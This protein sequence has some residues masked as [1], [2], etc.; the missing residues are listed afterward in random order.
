MN[1]VYAPRALRDLHGIS[2]YLAERSPGA[3][4][5]VLAALLD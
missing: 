5:H 1:V 3:S 4:V 2:A